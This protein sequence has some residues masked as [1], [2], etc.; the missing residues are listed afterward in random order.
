MYVRVE[1]GVF[2]SPL[3]VWVRQRLKD[4]RRTDL[5]H[6]SDSSAEGMVDKPEIEVA[7]TF[8]ER[9]DGSVVSSEG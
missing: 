7:A 4:V 1:R 3:E 2:G 8:Y 6:V 9:G 5:E